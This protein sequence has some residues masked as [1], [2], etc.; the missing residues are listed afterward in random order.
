MK[1]VIRSLAVSLMNVAAGHL[2]TN[3]MRCKY[4]AKCARYGVSPSQVATLLELEDWAEFEDG[5]TS[6]L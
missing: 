5:T 1:P 4:A 2:R 6:G 3:T